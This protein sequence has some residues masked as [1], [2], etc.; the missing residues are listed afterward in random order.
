MM[1]DWKHWRIGAAAG[2]ALLATVAGAVPALASRTAS[3]PQARYAA[4][5]LKATDTAHLRYVSAAGSLLS[6]EGSASGT[7][8][9]KMRASVNVGASIS[10]NFTIY[11]KGG[12]I[13]GHG[14]AT[15]HGSGSV[16]SFAGSIVLT[17]GTGRFAH[18]RG[19]T[20]LYGT[21]N[22]STYALTIQTTGTFS[23]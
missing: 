16:E 2:V 5:T 11:T 9:G 13:K 7:L 12:T 8:P 17:G 1:V 18:V 23:Y 14:S 6:E 20:G 3:S 21:F 15:P 10:G 22:R 19:K 4:R